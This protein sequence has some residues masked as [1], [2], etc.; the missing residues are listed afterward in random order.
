MGSKKIALFILTSVV[1]FTLGFLGVYYLLLPIPR[2]QVLTNRVRSVVSGDLNL[3][4]RPP[5]NLTMNNQTL[6]PASKINV[7][8]LERVMYDLEIILPSTEDNFFDTNANTMRTLT[9]ITFHLDFADS[10]QDHF[11]RIYEGNDPGKSRLA[12]GW[13]Y[14]VNPQ[15]ADSYSYY[16]YLGEKYIESAIDKPEKVQRAFLK[17]LATDAMLKEKRRALTDEEQTLV[18]ETASNLNKKYNIVDS[19]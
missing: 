4:S 12:Y 7:Q 17:M 9:T 11:Q 19:T 2:R 3:Q 14:E 8:E 6:F 15:A 1:F 13:Y 16:L 18:I 5:V 10:D